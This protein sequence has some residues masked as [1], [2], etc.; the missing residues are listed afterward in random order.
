MEITRAI[1]PRLIVQTGHVD[2]QR[3][4]LPVTVGPP[5]PTIAGRLRRRAHINDANRAS[6]FVSHQNV[7]L[8]LDDLKRIREIGGT[9]HARQITLH[10]R[11]QLHPIR[12]ILLLLGGRRRQIRDLIALDD[13]QAG[14]HGK[15]CSERGHGP[16]GGGMSLQVPIRRVEGLPD[17]V[18][19][20]FSI[21]GPRRTI[22]RGL[23]GTRYCSQRKNTYCHGNGNHRDA[24]PTSH[25][26]ISPHQNKASTRV[27]M[28]GNY[29]G[30]SDFVKESVERC[31]L[32][33][34]RRLREGLKSC[35]Q[36]Q[37]ARLGDRNRFHPEDKCL[38]SPFCANQF[39][40]RA[41]RFS[42]RCVA[43]TVR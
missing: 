36:K 18:Q 40:K 29:A 10:L 20:G 30:L 37:A 24:K 41:T 19:V 33:S 43:Q 32:A 34:R 23:A 6:V 28:R 12:L 9:W 16:L 25:R 3:F 5:H 4:A 27:V 2:H 14:R 22:S 26:R 35:S 38:W 13:A 8:R 31:G 39:R 42:V 15:D 21:R 11:I 7:L 1:E 17:S